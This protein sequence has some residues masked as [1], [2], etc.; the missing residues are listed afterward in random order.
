[1][2]KNKDLRYLLHDLNNKLCTT[3]LAVDSL[4]S[5]TKA[6]NSHIAKICINS[7]DKSIALT[8]QIQEKLSKNESAVDDKFPI[9][10]MNEYCEHLWEKS[11]KQLGDLYDLEVEYEYINNGPCMIY[12]HE[13]D[14]VRCD[15][16]LF[17]NSK[18]AGATKIT[19]TAICNDEYLSY[20]ISDNGVGMSE[21]VLNLL[22]LGVYSK[23]GRVGDGT[24]Y[25][26][27]Y[28][29]IFNGICQF[30][31]KEGSGTTFDLKFPT[32]NTLKLK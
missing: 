13:A 24:R 11:L 20:S 32:I 21:K 9:I 10:N 4:I 23:D 1:M 14:G 7:F 27:D 19:A 6:K 5:E 25:V 16:N 18:K 30:K 29:K 12:A 26:L 15:E 2:E 3:R 8:E 31:S 17:Q 28:V 22:N